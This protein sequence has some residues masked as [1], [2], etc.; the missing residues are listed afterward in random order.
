MLP[1]KPDAE[2]CGYVF[3]D[4]PAKC[5]RE[6][7]IDRVR[8]KNAPETMLVW[9]PEVARMAPAVELPFLQ[10]AI[11]EQIRK[12]IGSNQKA[13]IFSA[14]LWGLLAFTSRSGRAFQW[15]F[16]LMLSFGVIPIAEGWWRLRR[17]RDNGLETLSGRVASA[18]YALWVRRQDRMVTWVLLGVIILIFVLEM[19]R[20]FD[21]SIRRA[22]L[23]KT[24][25]RVSDAY[26]FLTAALLH[27]SVTHVVMNGMALAIL[28]MVLEALVGGA[29]LALIF[30]FSALCGNAS[31]Y[32]FISETSVGASGGIMGLVGCLAVLGF[33]FRKTL[34]PNFAWHMVYA[35]LITALTG[36]IAHS[37]I[38]NAAH[39]GGLLG[40]AALGWALFQGR[41]TL[42]LRLSPAAQWAGRASVALILIAAL[43]II[44]LML[45]VV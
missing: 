38:D 41:N 45:R 43:F 22:G 29:G 44:A 31:S 39:A 27:L 8:L 30:T 11:R 33:H 10:D 23:I 36:L 42:P 34:P 40:G 15:Q 3:R 1:E 17:L 12:R 14:I 24:E 18:R 6:K 21:F 20:G 4:I 5:T 7:L 32:L 25:V 16:M 9:A 28:G 13:A 26:R 37:V 19:G 35:I 2:S